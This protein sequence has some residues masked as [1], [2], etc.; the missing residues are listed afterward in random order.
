MSDDDGITWIGIGVI[1]GVVLSMIISF[2][3][4][5]NFKAIATQICEYLDE[6]LI[7]YEIVGKKFKHIKCGETELI[8]GI[9]VDK[10]IEIM[11]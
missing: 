1:I 5:P 7:D 11:K 6:G 4:M 9:E 3:T 8:E 2:F 10:L